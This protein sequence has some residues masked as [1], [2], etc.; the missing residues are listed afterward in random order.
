[1]NIVVVIK[2]VPDLVEELEIDA[3]GTSLD[4]T[5]MRLIPNEMD[6]HALEQALLLKERYGGK[7]AVVTLDTGDVD[8]TLFTAVAKGADRVIKIVGVQEELSNHAIT[9]ILGQVLS[10]MSWDLI[11][12]GTQANDDLDGSIGPLLAA[13]LRLP[14][15]GYITGISQ[16][17][18]QVI[19]RK[20]YPGGLIAEMVVT[21]PAV[22]GIQAAEKPPRYVVTSLVTQAMKSAR[23]EEIP[24]GEPNNDGAA[25][26]ARMSQP[27]ATTH[28]E[29][30]SGSPDQVATQLVALLA[31]RGLLQR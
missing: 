20:E 1:M 9:A 2:F 17:N 11:L 25:A 27:E 14:Y 28:A 16:T 3:S 19:A 29:M 24:A 10:D 12:T 5:F 22:I 7:V 31:E 13:R 26:V 21:L 15:V 23:I 18:G 30:L 8:E 4:R 6:E